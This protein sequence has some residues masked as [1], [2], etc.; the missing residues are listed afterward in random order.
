LRQLV[1][2][3]QRRFEQDMSCSRLMHLFAPWAVL[4]FVH[5]GQYQWGIKCPLSLSTFAS[6]RRRFTA[7][8]SFF[9]LRNDESM[10]PMSYML[11]GVFKWPCGIVML[12][13]STFHL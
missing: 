3:A 2:I 12:Q 9:S 13:C 4:T 5:N 11:V 8:Q 10:V 1:A 7:L 6:K